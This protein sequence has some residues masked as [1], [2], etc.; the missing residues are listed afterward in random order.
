MI[1]K[2]LK[3]LK[4]KP[5]FISVDITLYRKGKYIIVP[6]SPKNYYSNGV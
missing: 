5:S 1:N 4:L 6:N 2:I 3:M